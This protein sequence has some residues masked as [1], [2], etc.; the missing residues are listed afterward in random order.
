[1]PCSA[2]SCFQNSIPTAEKIYLGMNR[3]SGCLPP[4]PTHTQLLLTLVA[5]LSQ[6]YSDNFPRH[7]ATR[8]S[9]QTFQK[10]PPPL[11]LEANLPKIF[12]L[13]FDCSQVTQWKSRV[14]HMEVHM[15]GQMTFAKPKHHHLLSALK[16]ERDTSTEP[17]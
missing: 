14:S 3:L 15:G 7:C 1:M 9:N 12:R 5:T 10:A 11:A 13:K 4:H 2:Q 8:F 6:L 16:V 17:P